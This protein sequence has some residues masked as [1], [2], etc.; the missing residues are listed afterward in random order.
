MVFASSMEPAPMG[1]PRLVAQLQQLRQIHPE[2]VEALTVQRHY[3]CSV[4]QVIEVFL[5]E[6]CAN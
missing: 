5:V 3:V 1:G 4:L 6:W 2:D